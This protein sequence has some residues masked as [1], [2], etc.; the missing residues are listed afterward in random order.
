[1]NDDQWYVERNNRIY[2]YGTY[3]LD[4]SRW[5]ALRVD[6]KYAADYA[7][8]V[9]VL[10][11]AN[12]LGRMS[13]S[14]ALDIP[15]VPMVAPLPW[16]DHDLQEFVLDQLYSSDPCGR[17]WLRPPKED[18]CLVHLGPSGSGVLVHGE[19]WHA[20]LGPGPS[21]LPLA[22]NPN[23]V[24]PA[25]AAI[26]AA[27]RLCIH[28]LAPP[29]TELLLNAFS[30]SHELC[31]LDAPA[32]S[33]DAALGN[34]WSVG[35]GSVG[36]AILYFL[37]LLT[38]NFS[39]VLF[40][41]DCVERHNIIRSPIFTE[42]HVERRK[43]EV[44]GEY[45]DCC[46]VT[47]IT[48]YPCALHDS[49]AWTSREEGTPDLLIAAAN[50]LNVRHYIEALFP[51]VQIY[52]TTGR[53]WQATVM[54]HIPLRDPCSRCL[55]PSTTH[56]PTKCAADPAPVK[57]L[58]D[59]QADAALPFLSFAAGLMAACEILKL[60]LPD[61]PFFANRVFFNTQP[62]PRLVSAPTRHVSGCICGTRRTSVHWQMIN[63][64]R[65][66]ALSVPA[67]EP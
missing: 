12:L 56:A 67:R 42:A 52:G 1:M 14:I 35:T 15:R 22:H 57:T 61:Y 3:P 66:A 40:D 50:E 47:S 49:R 43:V 51:P 7:G 53:N 34:V 24:G 13:P 17:F 62:E 18:D 20:Y 65:F 63:K 4:P 38:R 48:A 31:L 5:I 11:A 10:T 55:F 36:T 29:P 30:W 16:A 27:T 26:L 6:S 23:P 44:T 59:E 45:L 9:A 32:L 64:S 37:T 19:G 58:D 21:P 46:G 39:A 60:T 8:Q 41:M 54:R 25:L 33:P 28:K 2:R